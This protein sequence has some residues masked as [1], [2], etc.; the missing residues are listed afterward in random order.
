MRS[1]NPG[2]LLQSASQDVIAD[3]ESP[4]SDGEA[5]TFWSAQFSQFD[6]AW[7]IGD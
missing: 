6:A 4:A 2:F 5:T 1:R 3:A 7:S